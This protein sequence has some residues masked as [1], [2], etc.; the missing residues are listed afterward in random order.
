MRMLDVLVTVRT[1]GYAPV[2][3]E[4]HRRKVAPREIARLVLYTTATCWGKRRRSS[5]GD[6][7]SIR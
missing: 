3:F 7:T 1:S 2:T 5:S 6:P 4:V